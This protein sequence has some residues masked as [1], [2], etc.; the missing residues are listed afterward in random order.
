MHG[1]SLDGSYRLHNAT[2][3]MLELFYS[4]PPDVQ[5]KVYL[6]EFS[7]EEVEASDEYRCE[8]SSPSCALRFC[9]YGFFTYSGS[10]EEYAHYRQH[11]MCSQCKD[12]N[13]R[14][15][16]RRKERLEGYARLN[17]AIRDDDWP[18]MDAHGHW[19]GIFS[20]YDELSDRDPD[21][22]DIME[23]ALEADRLNDRMS[24]I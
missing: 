8:P 12:K 1:M 18:G 24:D 4:L 23:M 6:N 13:D 11:G 2:H 19:S 5:E 7:S 9:L 21:E 16:A 17:Q 20:D 15:L 10:I 14:R 3:A 22:H